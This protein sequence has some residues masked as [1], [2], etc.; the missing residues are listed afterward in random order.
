MNEFVEGSQI[1]TE[2]GATVENLPISQMPENSVRLPEV[3]E[4]PSK[5][6]SNINHT[7]M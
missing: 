7:P 1:V 4:S 6:D 2:T 3:V 5:L